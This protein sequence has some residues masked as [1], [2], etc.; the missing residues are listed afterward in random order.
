[1]MNERLHVFIESSVLIHNPF[2]LSNHKLFQGIKLFIK[3]IFIKSFRTLTALEDDA[4]VFFNLCEK[5]NQHVSFIVK[6]CLMSVPYKLLVNHRLF[7]VAADY[8][9]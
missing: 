1:M 2:V 9:N 7:V 3:L 4:F 5:I 8:C 6:L